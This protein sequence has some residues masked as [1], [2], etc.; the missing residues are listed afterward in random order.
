MTHYYRSVLFTSTGTINGYYIYIVIKSLF[1][2]TKL[3][4]LESSFLS[5]NIIIA[6]AVAGV[7]G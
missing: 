4:L 5:Y 2:S 1:F 7:V 6:I 3:I